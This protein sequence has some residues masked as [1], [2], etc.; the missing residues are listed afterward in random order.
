MP[1]HQ[2]A[3]QAA[4]QPPLHEE[5]STP[6][7][8]FNQPF[9]PLKSTGS[10][11]VLHRQGRSDDARVSLCRARKLDGPSSLPKTTRRSPDLLILRLLR[12][13]IQRNLRNLP[14]PRI[15]T[16]RS[17]RAIA[18]TATLPSAADDQI[19]GRADGC[20]A[21]LPSAADQQNIGHGSKKPAPGQETARI[22]HPQT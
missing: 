3:P 18:C 17:I 15:K 13:P 10:G 21:A 5:R 14:P 7:S 12:R 20:G 4:S 16:S 22:N 6:T 1:Q 9:T 2:T 11:H 19:I 8:L